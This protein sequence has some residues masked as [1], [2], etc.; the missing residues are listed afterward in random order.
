MIDSYTFDSS[1]YNVNAPLK[2]LSSHG[3]HLG[4]VGLL[5]VPADKL[6]RRLTKLPLAIL[7]LKFFFV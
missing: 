4:Q 3:S 7:H 6:K 2:A 5:C 1:F